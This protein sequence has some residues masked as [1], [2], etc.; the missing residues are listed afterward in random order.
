MADYKESGSPFKKI[1]VSILLLAVG[2]VLLYAGVAKGAWSFILFGAFVLFI[3]IMI[4]FGK[5]VDPNDE[6]YKHMVEKQI[7]GEH[8]DTAKI[9]A[10][11][12]MKAEQMIRHPYRTLWNKFIK[13]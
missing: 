11:T 2:G 5:E 1:M 3:G 7:L 6:K 4:P 8:Y 9:A 13:K 10:D 12:A